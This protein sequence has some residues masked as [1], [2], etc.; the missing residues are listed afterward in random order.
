MIPQVDPKDQSNEEHGSSWKDAL[1]STP[2]SVQKSDI[3]IAHSHARCPHSPGLTRG[4]LNTSQ[5]HNPVFSGLNLDLGDV[6]RLA[7]MSLGSSSS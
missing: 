1:N 5:C 6:Y 2:E 7:I 3:S 4:A